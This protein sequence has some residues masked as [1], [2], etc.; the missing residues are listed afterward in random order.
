MTDTTAWLNLKCIVLIEKPDLKEYIV[1]N[2]T[3]MTF[4]K[5]QN[6]GDRKQVSIF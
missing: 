4:W 2:T 3:Y 6:Y 5:R 1:Y